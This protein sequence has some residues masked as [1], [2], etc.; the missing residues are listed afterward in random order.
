MAERLF[1]NWWEK[2]LHR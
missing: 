1:H 2:F